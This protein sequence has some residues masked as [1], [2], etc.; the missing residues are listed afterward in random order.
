[1]QSYKELER[2]ELLVMSQIP[3]CYLIAEDYPYG[4]FSAWLSGL[5]ESTVDRLELYYSVNPQKIPQY[6]Y[7][8]KSNNFGPLFLQHDEIV[9][10]AKT[11]GYSVEENDVSY[12]LQK[13]G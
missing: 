9:D 3:W 1:M 4:S 8:V 2:D 11:H 7:I 12:K 6:I 10:G 13:L 5:D